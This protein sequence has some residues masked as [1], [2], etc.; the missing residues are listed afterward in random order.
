GRTDRFITA[1]GV[2][3]HLEA[4]G[5]PAARISELDWWET[6]GFRGLTITATPARHFSGRGLTGRQQTL[7]CGFALERAT[8]EG[9]GHKIYVSGDSGYDAHFKQIGERLGPFDLTLMECGQYSEYWP[10]LHMNPEETARAHL[11]A[12]GR[13]LLPVHWG[14]FNLSLHGWTEPVERLL[15]AAGPAGISVATPMIGQTWQLGTEPPT[16]PWWSAVDV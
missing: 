1:L 3:A 6:L 4:W 5:V 14:A 15:R 11:D 9:S 8:A 7:W 13:V 2:G 12:G 10:E 16:L